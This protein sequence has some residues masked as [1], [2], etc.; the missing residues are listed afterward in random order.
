MMRTFTRW[1]LLVALACAGAAVLALPFPGALWN[2]G[3]STEREV[4]R[5][6]WA[7]LRGTSLVLDGA[8][9]D[10]RAAEAKRLAAV[11]ARGAAAVTIDASVPA[12]LRPAVDSLAQAAWRGLGSRASA[13]TA[14]LL[15]HFDTGGIVLGRPLPEPRH[16]AD[17]VYVLPTDDTN[18]RCMVVVRL[19]QAGRA[20]LPH[21]DDLMGPCGFYAAFGRPGAGVEEWLQASGFAFAW[22][23]DRSL[24]SF[25]ASGDPGLRSQMPAPAAQC[26]T[27][28]DAECARALAL[29]PSGDTTTE[30]PSG[31]RPPASVARRATI[32][33]LA[34]A[35]RG[36]GERLGPDE[37]RFFAG[38]VEEFGE[39]RFETFWRSDQNDP[40]LAFQQAMGTPLDRWT[41][42]WL[43]ETVGPRT[44]NA[45]PE[46]RDLIWL[47]VSL[48]LLTMAAIR[49]RDHVMWGARPGGSG[50]R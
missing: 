23:T 28:R 15:V 36:A 4:L 38:M 33:P 43:D 29:R 45:R 25:S 6:Q 26:Q 32:G 46:P 31:S 5:T 2:D 48:P 42:Q 41:R 9:R 12:T 40:R 7:R 30:D 34:A 39:D 20:Q 14:G 1:A 49:R 3:M 18:G 16:H 35:D 10:H 13:R 50:E 44:P 19:R 17:V 27:R 24:S 21:A 22:R 8:V 37:G 47:A 11:A